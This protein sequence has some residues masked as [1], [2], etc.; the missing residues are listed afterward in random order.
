MYSYIYSVKIRL[1]D[2]LVFLVTSFVAGQQVPDVEFTPTVG[3]AAYPDHTGPVILVDEAHN[4]FHTIQNRFQPFSLLLERDGY[5][6]R[7][8]DSSLSKAALKGVRILVISNALNE[9]NVT[10]WSLPNPS[11]FTDEEIMAVQTWVKKG[12][13]LFLIADHMPF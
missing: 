7:G 8:G 2:I 10:N 9:N 6:L 13:S 3:K 4:N 1:T 11:A 12:G 5:Q